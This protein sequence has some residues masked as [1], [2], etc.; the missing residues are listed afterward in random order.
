MNPTCQESTYRRL[1]MELAER[2]RNYLYYHCGNAQAAEDLAQEAF[3]RLWEHCKKVPPEKAKAFVYRV[4]FNLMLDMAKHKKVVRKFETA[5][6]EHSGPDDP[7][8]QVEQHE[9]EERLWAVIRSMPE[10]N[11]V[12]FL[13][14][15]LDGMTYKQI[16]EAIGVTDKAVEKRMQKA[17]GAIREIYPK[18]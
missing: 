2:L 18:F 5:R 8:F 16:A 14:N 1:F 12:V 10:K 7:H 6:Q 9:F 13:M 3:I 4:G 15:R 11:R 17:L